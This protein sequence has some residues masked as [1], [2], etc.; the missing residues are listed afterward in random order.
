MQILSEL[1]DYEVLIC[2][3]VVLKG[4]DM[5]CCL[6]C[7]ACFEEMTNMLLLSAYFKVLCPEGTAN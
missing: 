4:S 6:T 1:E 2:K 7:F 5:N 3:F